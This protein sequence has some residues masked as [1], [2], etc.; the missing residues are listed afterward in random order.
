MLKN[1]NSLT[2]CRYFTLEHSKNIVLFDLTSST[3]VYNCNPK[4]KCENGYQGNKAP[5]PEDCFSYYLCLEDKQGNYFHPITL[6]DVQMDLI[7]MHITI[8]VITVQ[9]VRVSV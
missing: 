5:N 3:I 9:H 7:M 2:F 4:E 1:L 6:S 8:H